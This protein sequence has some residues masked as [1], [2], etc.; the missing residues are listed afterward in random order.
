MIDAKEM[1]TKAQGKPLE[2]ILI[3][4][5]PTPFRDLQ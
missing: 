3:D 2:Q 1:Q 5:N 4:P